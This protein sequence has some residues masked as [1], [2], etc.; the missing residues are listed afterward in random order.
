MLTPGAENATCH[1]Y[2]DGLKYVV[3]PP[4]K[5]IISKSE[6]PLTVECMAPGGRDKTM[7]IPA[8]FADAAKWNV[9]NA[10]AGLP[11]DAAS[12]SLWAYP[13]VIEVD[14]SD[15][16]IQDPPLPAHN[17]PDIR[18]PETYDLEE[19]SPSRP[20][21][22]SDKNAPPVEILRREGASSQTGAFQSYDNS[23]SEP[24]SMP[25]GKGGGYSVNDDAGAPVPLL[26]GE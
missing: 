12:R 23:F 15:V 24:S 3:K 16:A 21:L 13:S 17:A 22:N 9:A 4:Q 20:R 26:P 25:A 19:F 14:F 5:T 6:N 11:W 2:V 10:G 8:G 1:L 7:E 18:Q